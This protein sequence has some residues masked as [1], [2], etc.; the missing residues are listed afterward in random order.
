MLQD[1]LR[2]CRIPY[3]AAGSPGLLGKESMT[4][5]YCTHMLHS[6]VISRV[7]I[8]IFARCLK[9]KKLH[10]SNKKRGGGRG[11]LRKNFLKTITKSSDGHEAR[12][13]KG[14]NG[15]AISEGTFFFWRKTTISP[16]SNGQNK[17]PCCLFAWI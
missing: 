1:P 9:K 6:F 16:R 15:L 2:C 3:G 7:P 5:C 10:R 11:V 14:L 17:I 12:V 4:V 8:M 13:G